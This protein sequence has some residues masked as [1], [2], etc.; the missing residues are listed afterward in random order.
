MKINIIEVVNQYEEVK[1]QEKLIAEKKK[2]LSTVLKNYAI[3]NGQQDSKG[4]SY[5]KVDGNIVG[6]V[7]SKKITFNPEKAIAYMTEHKPELVSEVMETVQI[8]SEAKIE[9]LVSKGELSVDD[10]AEMVDTKLTPRLNVSKE[11]EETEQDEIV[12]VKVKPRV[13][14]VL[15]KL[16]K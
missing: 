16:K 4:S 8:V 15:K 12:E 6:N 3:E 2:E 10:V 7:V 13:K 11:V 1:K 9:T 14:K 5:A